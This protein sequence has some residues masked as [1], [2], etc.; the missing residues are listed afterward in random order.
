MTQVFEY[1]YLFATIC[2]YL[3]PKPSHDQLDIIIT[4]MQSLTQILIQNSIE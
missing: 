2:E 4:Q 3:K 1:R